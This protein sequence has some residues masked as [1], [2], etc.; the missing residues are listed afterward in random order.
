MQPHTTAA[1][2]TT[3]QKLKFETIN[4]PPYGPDLASTIT[5]LARLWKHCEDED[6]T[7]TT[8][9]RFLA[10]DNKQKLFFLLEYRSLSKDVKCITKDGDCG[11]ITSYL[12]LY[13]WC[14]SQYNTICPYLLKSPCTRMSVHKCI[15]LH[16]VM[17]K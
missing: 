11:K 10:F 12:Y 8:R 5:C 15:S 17:I 3:I 7:G 16:I 14:A 13:I 2:V 4:W 1:T 9:W 6:F